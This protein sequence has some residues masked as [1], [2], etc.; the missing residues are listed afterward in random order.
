MLQDWQHAFGCDTACSHQ[1][2]TRQRGQV[3]R[4]ALQMLVEEQRRVLSEKR[5]SLA[6]DSASGTRHTH[7]HEQ[8]QALQ[9]RAARH[10]CLKR[11]DKAAI[12]QHDRKRLQLDGQRADEERG[13]PGARVTRE[14]EVPQRR[15]LA[16][17]RQHA[18]VAKETLSQRR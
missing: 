15:H 8:T 10:D 9:S 2:Q 16:E 12:G 1:M 11:F 17:R 7:L 4:Q 18:V 3:R 13:R 14:L 5:V 6:A